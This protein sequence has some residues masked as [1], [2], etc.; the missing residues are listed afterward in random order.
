MSIKSNVL[1]I[2][3][4]KRYPRA[5][6]CSRINTLTSADLYRGN[7]QKNMIISLIGMAGS[8][9]S[10]WSKMLVE[11]GFKRFCC[12]ELIAERLGPDLIRSD[13]SL[14]NMGEWMGFPY[15]P[16]YKR[17]ESQYLAHEI[18][19]ITE[20][21]D[22]L[23]KNRNRES[24]DTVVDTTGSVIYIGVEILQRLR[25]CSTVVYL[26][27]PPEIRGKLLKDYVTRPHPMLWKGIFNKRPGET[28][29]K[30]LERC[31]SRLVS[32]RERLYAQYADVTIGYYKRG[33]KGFG[34]Q[35]FLHE[36]SIEKIS[37]RCEPL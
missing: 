33:N 8:G 26:S 4:G 20:I 1:V 10:H 32:T 2:C 25:R 6:A 13:G 16:R 35:E 11:H 29:D 23:E 22:Y 5:N 19:V 14:M 36:I 21:I 12:D 28:N 7:I 9:K 15:E 17:R 24:N 31:Y 37:Q 27:T 3:I 30:A 34:V 18:D